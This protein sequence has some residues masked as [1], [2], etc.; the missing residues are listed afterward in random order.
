MFGTTFLRSMPHGVAAR[1]GY[2]HLVAGGR[3]PGDTKGVAVSQFSGR[4]KNWREAAQALD[5]GIAAVLKVPEVSSE[6]VIV[7]GGGGGGGVAVAIVVD[8]ALVHCH[9]CAFV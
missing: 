6:V 3:V 7:G 8:L 5:S 2:E 4:V 9:D 1:K